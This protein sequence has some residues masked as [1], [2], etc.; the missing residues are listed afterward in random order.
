MSDSLSRD[1][2]SLQIQRN[3]PKS[4]NGW[5]KVLVGLVALGAFGFVGVRFGK[6]WVESMFFKTEVAVTEISS[7][8]PA[9]AQ[10]DVTSTGYVQPAAVVKVG[11]KITARIAKA[12]VREGEGVKKGQVLFELDVTDD[13]ALVSQAASRVA[14]AD[15]RVGVARANLHEIT[16]QL[17]RQKALTESGAAPKSQL[18]DMDA[19]TRG[20]TEQV[21]AAEADAVAARADVNARAVAVRNAMVVSPIDGT[22]LTK[23]AQVGDIANPTNTLV[24]IADM[25]LLMIETDVPEGRMSLVKQNGPCEIVL[26]AY[27]NQRFRGIVAEIS[28]RINRSKATATIKVKFVD[29]PERLQPDMSARVSFLAK[30]IDQEALKAKPKTVVPASA[31]AKRGG[32]SVVFVLVEG[33]TK[34]TNVTLG[35]EAPGGF[36]LIEGPP[37]GTR[38]VRE[39]PPALT[40]GQ[41]VKEKAS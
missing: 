26:D 21:R 30:A 7:I 38:V 10:T 23:A 14:A 36:E 18:E 29:M 20:L 24:E 22:A 5:A 16:V 6:P 12:N 34:L 19:K 37:P 11:S 25:T 31:L 8:S 15:A 1:L 32:S 13:A 33:K 41:A 39:P 2:A 28:P 3:A 17:T 40:D 4:S 27:P 9:Q 35:P